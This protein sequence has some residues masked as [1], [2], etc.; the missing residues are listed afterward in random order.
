MKTSFFLIFTAII[1]SVYCFPSTAQD[2]PQISLPEDTIARLGKGY[3]GEVHFSPDGSQLA[4]STSIGIWFHD[5]QTGKLL[6]L[7]KYPN[8]MS[9]FPF[10]FSPDGNRIGIGMRTKKK[11]VSRHSRY[12][13]EV[14]DTTTGKKR[15][16]SWT[17]RQSSSH[18]L[19]A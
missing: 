4:I 5:P 9:P 18:R 15:D 14:W 7:L 2:N 17:R 6:E 11:N 12:S 3:I 16:A 8:I 10:A 1:I 13:V 19:F